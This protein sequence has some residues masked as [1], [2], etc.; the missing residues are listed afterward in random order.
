MSAPVTE[1]FTNDHIA[2]GKLLAER[3][4]PSR[5]PAVDGQ[6]KLGLTRY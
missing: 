6:L 5:A 1:P 3:H 2:A 4:H